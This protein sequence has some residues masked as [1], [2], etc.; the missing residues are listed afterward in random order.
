M[1]QNIVFIYEKNQNTLFDHICFLN[2]T[3]NRQKMALR[4]FRSDFQKHLIILALASFCPAPTPEK[5][6]NT[7]R[8]KDFG[9][10]AAEARP[11]VAKASCRLH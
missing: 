6:E 4:W 10:S 2:A 1:T 11:R 5:R 9:G 7:A 3:K 8:V